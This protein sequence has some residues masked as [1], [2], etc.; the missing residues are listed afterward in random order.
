MIFRIVR[1]KKD[2]LRHVR[3]EL[4]VLSKL[5]QHPEI[6]RIAKVIMFVLLSYI[7]SPI[8]LIPDFIPMIGHLDDFLMIPISFWLIEKV[9]PVEL[10]LQIRAEVAEDPDI[11]LFS[12]WGPKIFAGIIL[13]LWIVISYLTA[14]ALGLD[15]HIPFIS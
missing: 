6:P 3:G 7:F 13:V 12:G 14:L 1:K 11:A 8:D 9:T 10:I 2:L 5:F 15:Q 4:I